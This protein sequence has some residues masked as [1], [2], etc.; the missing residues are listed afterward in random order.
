MCSSPQI[1]EARL[2]LSLEALRKTGSL[3]LAA[4]GYSML[5]ALWPGD[6]LTIEARSIDKIRIG[7]VVLF[8]RENRFF[9]HRVVRSAGTDHGLITRGD[10]MPNDD[11]VLCREELLGRVVAVHRRQADVPVAGC[12]ALT[13]CCGLI[14]AYSKRL[15]SL[16]VRYHTMRCPDLRSASYLPSEEPAPSC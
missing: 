12:S 4:R 1:R 10:D 9:V 2:S 14:L 8:V 7:D 13:R 15:R 16:A 11:G 6:V 5:P 3:R